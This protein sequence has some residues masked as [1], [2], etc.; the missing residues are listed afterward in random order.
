[1]SN[2]IVTKATVSA[3]GAGERKLGESA[4]AIVAATP[5]DF[6]HTVRGAVANLLREHVEDGQRTR[7]P[8]GGQVTT[9]YGRGFKSLESAVK[10]RLKARAETDENKPVVLRVALSGKDGGST[11]VPADHPLYGALV[12]LIT[13]K[14]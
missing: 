2:I 3:I 13:G 12:E 14:N 6:D 7:G 10:N 11:V 9:D 4:D 8:A 5:L 1:M